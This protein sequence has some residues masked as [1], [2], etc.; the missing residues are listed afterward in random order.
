[1][2]FSPRTKTESQYMRPPWRCYIGC[3]NCNQWQDRITNA[4]GMQSCASVTKQQ[5]GNWRT[6][7]TYEMASHWL[8]KPQSHITKK[9]TSGWRL[10]VL[11]MRAEPLTNKLFNR[12]RLVLVC[13]R[14]E[15][16]GTSG[17][18]HNRLTA[19]EEETETTTQATSSDSASPGS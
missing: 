13:R 6:P 9:E 3:K 15:I 18:P 16:A 4:G 7:Q 8:I 11:T 12:H 1:M 17:V 14:R 10:L 19:S 5:E 2:P